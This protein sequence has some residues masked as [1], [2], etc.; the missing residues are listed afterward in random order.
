MVTSGT[1]S[2]MQQRTAGYQGMPFLKPHVW[3]WQVPLYF[4]LGG[5]GGMAAV[6]ALAALAGGRDGE[7]A[8]FV[9]VAMWVAAIAGGVLSPALLTWDLGRPARFLHMLRVFKW[10]S[11]MSV[12]AWLLAA[13]GAVAVPGAA[14]AEWHL[15]SGGQTRWLA[16]LSGAF[17]IFAGLLGAL[18]AV[19][20]G[21]LIG[22]TAVPAWYL[23]R[24]PLPVHFGVAGLGSAAAA[25]E[26][27]G[28]GRPPRVALGFLAAAV[29][30]CLGV[31]FEV[32]R[33][34]DADLA[35]RSGLGGWLLRAG[36]LLAGPL[37][38]ALRFAGWHSLAAAVFL[39]GALISRFGWIEAGRKGALSPEAVLAA[40]RSPRIPE[41]E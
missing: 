9:R 40:G 3:T 19:Y 31:W 29:E 41:E 12:G 4:F 21:V 39:A 11:P 2:E 20:T 7:D 17:V 16:L 30:T 18:L 32:R 35:L 38:L 28:L 37:A 23:H 1:P 36:G 13:F 33:H 22:A 6:L 15:R 25:L 14:L 27:L 10:R 34:G 8:Q 5:L 24:V 26:L